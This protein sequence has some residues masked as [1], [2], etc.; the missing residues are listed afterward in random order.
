M[1]DRLLYIIQTLKENNQTISMAES[2]TGGRV[3]AAFTSVAGASSVFHGS[4]VT[5]SNE[6]KHLWLGVSK[7]VLEQHG[8]V[9]HQCVTEMLY[10]IQKKAGSDYAIAIS[11]IAGPDGGSEEKPVGTVYIGLLTPSEINITEYHFKG[12][13]EAVQS[14]AANTAIKLFE[15]NLKKL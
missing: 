5:Y 14:D 4:C 13:R 2:C 8:A 9:S 7:E 6:V 1:K 12:D 3:V 10:G 11:G 15:K